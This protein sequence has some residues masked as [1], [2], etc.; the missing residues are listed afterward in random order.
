MGSFREEAL[1][2]RGWRLDRRLSLSALAAGI[3]GLVT[4]AALIA[5]LAIR[6]EHLEV[7]VGA[8]D[9]EARGARGIAIGMA[10]LEERLEALQRTLEE[11]RGDMRRLGRE[12]PASRSD[13]DASAG[14]AEP[15]AA[16]EGARKRL[17]ALCGLPGALAPEPE[18]SAG[19]AAAPE[20]REERP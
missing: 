8:L 17:A 7:R 1:Q 14:E 13:A 5:G 12:V 2:T 6:V 3:S 11:L 20:Y 16:R 10:R 4:A 9:A 18:T 19:N 15:G